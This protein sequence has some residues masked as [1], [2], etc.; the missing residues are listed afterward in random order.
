MSYVE[1]REQVFVGLDPRPASSRQRGRRLAVRPDSLEDCVLGLVVNELQEDMMTAL[2]DEVARRIGA[3]S[4]V[5]VR[6]SG[7]AVPMDGADWDRLTSEAQ[8]AITG[9]GG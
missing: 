2:G 9:Y 5:K 7:L 8:V 6:K 3:R 1:M 4:V